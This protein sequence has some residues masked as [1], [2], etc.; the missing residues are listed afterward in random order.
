MQTCRAFVA[1]LVVCTT[2]AACA[3][4]PTAAADGGQ[5]LGSG[6]RESSAVLTSSGGGH[7]FGGG[8]RTDSTAATSSG[9]GGFTFGGGN[10][11]RASDGS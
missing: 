5:T 6:H 4:N 8:N 11:H 7:T 3:G 1:G 2:L 9:G 10:E